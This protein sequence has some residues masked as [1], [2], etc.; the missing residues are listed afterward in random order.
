[1]KLNNIKRGVVGTLLVL[2]L[3]TVLPAAQIFAEDGQRGHK[4]EGY[5]DIIVRYEEAV[6][7]EDSLDPR[8][9][10][11]KT[12]DILPIQ[13]MSVPA[14]ALKDISLQENVRRITYDQEVETS[15]STFDVSSEDWNQDMIGT[16]DAWEDGYTG[17]NVNVAVLDTGF[18]QHPEIDYAGGHSIFGD[19]DELGADPWTNDHSGHG[20]HVAGILGA[21]QGTRA[22][23]IAPGIN[24]YGVKVYHEENGSKTRVG[25]LLKGFNWAINNGSD[26]IIISSG[27]ADPNN[28]VHEMIQVAASQGIMTIAA[29]GNMTDDNTTID[30]PAAHPEVIAVSGVNQRQARVSDSMVA[31]ENELAAPGQNILGLSTDG[32]HISM[33]GTS[34][35]V[36][37]VAGIAALLMEKYPNE[38]ASA[39]RQRMNNK[40]LDLGEEGRDAL[41]GF[42]LVQYEEQRAEESDEPADEPSDEEGDQADDGTDEDTPEENDDTLDETDEGTEPDPENESVSEDEPASGDGEEDSGEDEDADADETDASDEDLSDDLPD[43]ETTDVADLDEETTDSDLTDIDEE[44]PSEEETTEEEPEQH[45]TVW[46]RPSDTNGVATIAEEDIQSVAENGVLAV[47]FDSTLAHISRISLSREQIET[48]KEMNVS[49]LVARADLEWVIP[50]SNLSEKNAL[51]TFE[52][53]TAAVDF[54]SLSKGEVLSFGIDQDG[55]DPTAYPSQMTYRFF[56]PEAEYNQDALYEWNEAEE[57]WELLGDAYTKGGVVGVTSKTPTLAVFNPDELESAQ[58]AEIEDEEEPA[59]KE[60]DQTETEAEEA[61]DEETDSA[62]LNRDSSGLPVVLTS[63]VVLVLSVTGGFYFF[64][65]K[66]K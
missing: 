4:A 30:Y 33:S 46:V 27:Y 44:E 9:K 5:I 20:T 58:A 49:L 36:P 51:I 43:S 55:E 21:A 63:V 11:I 28:E 19:D 17:R 3:S 52:A 60:T 50:S 8:F 24:L 53:A 65:N 2:F 66:T 16:F 7:E 31:Y 47:S 32:L 39:I 59:D 13:T 1:M 15:Q 35:A 54:E 10:N 40:A 29:S 57:S 64:G 34:Q 37:H 42:G 48:L 56:T 26:I 12:L 23:G 6:P 41:Y 22:Q 45:R 38:S 25:N 61:D 62:F 18:Y 14:S